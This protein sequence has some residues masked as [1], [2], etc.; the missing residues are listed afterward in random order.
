MRMP[1]GK[2]FEFWNDGTA[3][4]R[5][6]HVARQH[7]RAADENPGT[8]DQPLR[9]IGRAA[10]LLQ[11]GE[12]V[13]IHEGVYRERVAPARGGASASAMIAYEAAPGERV[14][15]R[16]SER[17]DPS[18]AR[19]RATDRFD[20]TRAS[21]EGQA[22][23]MG[24]LPDEIFQGYNPFLINNTS[25]V[26]LLYGHTWTPAEMKRYLLKRGMLLCD[27]LPLEQVH[28][29]EELL[30]GPG[31]FWVDVASHALHFRLPGDRDPAT[32]DLELTTREQIFAPRQRGL[33]YIRVSGLIVEHAADPMTVLT[34]QHG[35]LSTGAGHHWIIEDCTVRHCNA[36][37]ID[38]GLQE[39]GRV[40][41][42]PERG[43]HVIR[44]NR[45][46]DCGIT[47][48]CG[49]GNPEDTLVEG[50]RFE[51]IGGLLI[52][53]MFEC[54][55]L[56]FHVCRRVLIRGNVFRHLRQAC[57]IWLDYHCGMNRVTGNVFQDIDSIF[58]GVHVESSFDPHWIDGNVFW[59]MKSW[60]AAD[61]PPE[62]PMRGGHGVFADSCD[63][64]TVAHNFFGPTASYAVACHFKQAD[65]VVFGRVG[66]NRGHRVLNNVFCR[67]A[68]R[69]LFGRREDNV[70]DGNVYDQTGDVGSL[71]L[72]RPEPAAILNLEIWRDYAALDRHSGQ[73]RVSAEVDD[74]G[75]SLM[76][77]RGPSEV[78]PVPV[79]DGMDYEAPG[80]FSAGVWD[81]AESAGH[82]AL[83]PLGSGRKTV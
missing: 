24:D 52:E 10:G 2:D 28:A 36:T 78:R 76:F 51:K 82:P 17:W 73:T 15:L 79:P 66:L 33:G 37:G 68:K 25:E 38:V 74:S 30:E 4:R 32:A 31:R 6:L 19:F 59:D 16:G 57:G 9:T 22:V 27:G 81:A 13:V 47:G 44:R 41:P 56:K 42:P 34:V 29:E 55:G 75:D 70:C 40:A 8:C 20:L 50:N 45:I 11:P 5:V 7:P 63:F 1:D 62:S 60:R 58:G 49:L 39:R 35:A 61:Y 71:C 12:K 3:Y 53:R 48:L 83:H 14:V 80:P 65:R 23:L 21:A 64:V 54:A 69:V 46:S 77:R 67:C 18:R 43:H 26:M 72:Y